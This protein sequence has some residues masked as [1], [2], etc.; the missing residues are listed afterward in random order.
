[1]NKFDLVLQHLCK[2]GHITSLEAINLYGATRLSDIIF[3]LRKSS[4]N[5]NSKYEKGI[6]RFGNKIHYVQ[7]ELVDSASDLSFLENKKS[8]MLRTLNS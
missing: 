1:M 8:S 3:K 6:D 2:Y 5:I 4:L 7:Y